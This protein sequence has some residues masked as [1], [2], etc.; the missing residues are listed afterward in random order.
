MGTDIHAVFQKKTS[1]GWE[2]IPSRWEQNR[3]Y[4]LFSFLADVRNGYGFAGVRTYEPVIPVAAPRGYPPDFV[5]EDDEH[6]V[7]CA[8]TDPHR[9]KYRE[10]GEPIWMGDHSH[11]WLTGKEILDHAETL[12][13]TVRHGV[14]SLETYNSWDRR[15]TPTDYCGGISG[16]EILVSDPTEICEK[17]THVRI[18][19]AE[20]DYYSLAYFLDEVARL[21]AEHGEIRLVMGFDS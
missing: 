14:V 10:P 16:P 17:T 21:V 12:G 2:D 4:F 8:N 5:V 9:E 20:K 3:H 13:S 19:W 18:S 1:T 7:T 6:P 11:T 15:S